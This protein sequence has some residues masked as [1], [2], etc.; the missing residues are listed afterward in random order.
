MWRGCKHPRHTRRVI[1]NKLALLIDARNVLYRAIY[2][3]RADRR[4]DIK[5]HYLVVLLRQF[6]SWIRDHDPTSV[7]VF[8]DAPRATVWRRAALKTYKDR[9]NSQYVEDISEDLATTTEAATELFQFLNIRQ[10]SRK[11][12]EAD[13]LIYAAATV[14]HPQKSIIISTDSDLLQ[15][16]FM[17]N[18]ASVFDPRKSEFA[19]IPDHHPAMMKSIVGDK[20]DAIDGYYGIGPKKGTMLLENPNHLQEFLDFK[21]REIY[22]RNLLLTD[23][24]LCPRLLANKLYVQ[25]TI[26]EPVVFDKS[27]IAELIK[28]H[29]LLGLDSEYVN[30]IPLFSKLS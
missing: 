11:Q 25:R 4:H 13:D 10:Y 9:S 17:F 20:S 28:K 14:L 5:Y 7:H 16:P 27:K 2:A 22:H 3:V 15:I 1:M 21:G 26:A 12:M 29:K 30:I 18:S 23:L 24:S 19:A 8:W 6:A